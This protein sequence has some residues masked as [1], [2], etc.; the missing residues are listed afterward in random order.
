MART[1][2]IW[3]AVPGYRGYYE[4]SSLGRVRSLDRTVSRRGA[5]DVRIR[6]RGRLMRQ[7]SETEYPMVVLCKDGAQKTFPTHRL[8]LMSFLGPRPRG[9]EAR[10]LNGNEYDARL[11]NL[12]WG[13][14]VEN[15]ADQIRHGTIARGE[16]NGRAK[17]CAPRVR[18]MRRIRK[19]R[20]L[21]Y[22][23]LA[24]LF[25]ISKAAAGNICCGITW[26]HV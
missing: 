16:V 5:P 8:V 24:H 22:A 3:K 6:L 17:M 25:G 13:T 23:A 4:V 15:T 7:T 1:K 26:R 11:R 19:S 14:H 21:S 18:K 2:E 9:K 20:G 12:A 10:H